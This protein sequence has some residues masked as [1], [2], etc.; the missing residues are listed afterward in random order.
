MNAFWLLQDEN[1]TSRRESE[2]FLFL[3]THH[4]TASV[5]F[6]RRP[7]VCRPVG[8]VKG[9]SVCEGAFGEIPFV[10]LASVVVER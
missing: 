10:P 9:A 2:T 7:C 8:F 6:N 5:T 4:I 1:I 3:K